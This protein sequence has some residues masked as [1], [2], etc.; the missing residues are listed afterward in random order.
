MSI[1]QDLRRA[2]EATLGGGSSEDAHAGFFELGGDSMLV[3]QLWCRIEA[4]YAGD[5]DVDAFFAK[6]T[7]ATMLAILS[8][9]EAAPARDERSTVS[10]SQSA[11]P[12]WPMSA[13]LHRRLLLLVATSGGERPTADR[14]VASFHASGSKIPIFF[15]CPADHEVKGLAAHLGSDQP[16]Y[17]FRSGQRDVYPSEEEVQSLALRYVDDLIDVYP[18][19]PILIGGSCQSGMVALAMAEHLRRRQRDVPL[20]ILTEWHFGLQCYS[21]RA[22]L[23]YG[24]EGCGAALYR[25]FA[26]SEP[27]WRRSFE[28]LTVVDVPGDHLSLLERDCASTVTAIAKHFDR[29]LALPTRFLPEDARSAHITVKDLPC[30]L[31][32]GETRTLH[33]EVENTSWISWSTALQ[34]GLVLANCWLDNEGAVVVKVDALAAL[35]KLD[36][37]ERETLALQVTAPQIS[38]CYS[39]VIDV[40]TE[41]DLLQDRRSTGAFVS[42]IEVT[43]PLFN[44]VAQQDGPAETLY[45]VADGTVLRGMVQ[46]RDAHFIVP[47]GTRELRIVSRAF[48]AVKPD[49]RTLGV[50][51]NKI[52]IS[53]RTGQCEIPLDDPAL[54]SGFHPMETHGAQSW[55]WTSGTAHLKTDLCTGTADLFM[56]HLGGQFEFS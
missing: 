29:A 15:V 27:S 34:G 38:A 3:V 6:P 49:L 18:R 42:R 39:L 28:E 10:T 8:Q 47:G 32:P 35:A 44:P 22:L 46:P 26:A 54:A 36:P 25:A 16:L 24:R 7:F 43:D 48:P 4:F 12:F 19:G 52:A 33:V 1:E 41:E 31:S 37:G 2:W 23:L 45:V 40:S 50:I 51:I 21:G 5:I 53:N 13:A 17:V 30:S 55:V 9:H 14:L 20:L 56:L 11:A